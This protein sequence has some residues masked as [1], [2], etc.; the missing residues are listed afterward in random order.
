MLIQFVFLFSTQNSFANQLISESLGQAADR[1]ITSRELAIN[2]LME[3]SYSFSGLPFSK[4][5]QEGPMDLSNLL[6]EKVLSLEANSLGVSEA[7]KPEIAD[8]VEITTKQNATKEDWS[9][10]EPGKAELEKMAKE[11]IEAKKFLKFKTS[12]LQVDVTDEE[13]R[14][15]FEKNRIKFGNLPFEKFRE[16]VKTFIAQQQLEEKLRA[17][18]E[19]VKRKYKVR[20]LSAKGTS[21][22]AKSDAK[23]DTK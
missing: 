11:K 6:L 1:V 14:L 16:N 4:I 9:K 10:L 21:E 12:S 3:K 19:V 22:K 20:V 8:L 18:F 2:Q 5:G 13:A 15:Y 7:T 23:P 17:W